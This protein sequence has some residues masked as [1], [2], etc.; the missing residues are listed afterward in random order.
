MKKLTCLLLLLFSLSS[1]GQNQK[2]PEIND[3]LFD[4]E[5]QGLVQVRPVGDIEGVAEHF[6]ALQNEGLLHVNSQNPK[7]WELSDQKK[8]IVFNGDYMRRGIYGIRSVRSILALQSQSPENIHIVI[9]NH[10]GN[11]LSWPAYHSAI[12]TKLGSISQRYSS[13]LE[14]NS[15]ENTLVNQVYFWL[16]DLGI[17]EKLTNFWLEYILIEKYGVEVDDLHPDVAKEFYSTQDGKTQI[18]VAKLD[19]VVSRDE[20]IEQ[21]LKFI[22]PGGPAFEILERGKLRGSIDFNGRKDAALI[23]FNHSGISSVDNFGVIPTTSEKYFKIRDSD[24]PVSIPSQNLHSNSSDRQRYDVWIENLNSNFKNS[25][26]AHLSS[27][28][29]GFKNSSDINE[30]RELAKRM[31]DYEIIHNLDA[32]WSDVSGMFFRSDSQVYPDPRTIKEN[33]LPGISSPEVLAVEAAIGIGIKLGGHKPV[34]DIATLMIGFD[35][36]SRRHVL[37]VYHDTSYSPVEGNNQISI[38]ENGAIRITGRLRDD[39]LVLMERPA[40]STMTKWQNEIE[41][42]LTELKEAAEQW[43]DANV[44]DGLENKYVRL[45]RYFRLGRVIGGRLIIGFKVNMFEGQAV[46]D[47]DTYVTVRQDGY[48]FKYQDIDIWG[49]REYE[50]NNGPLEYAQS[51]LGEMLLKAEVEK[52]KKLEEVGRTVLDEQDFTKA[53]NG[54][55]IRILSGPSANVKQVQND[56]EGGKYIEESL[57]AFRHELLAIPDGE[58]VVFLTGGT[59]GWESLKTSVIVEVN[60][61][62]VQSGKNPFRIIGCAALVF[63]VGEID[64]NIKEFFLIPKTFYWNDYQ[65]NLV[66]NYVLPSSAKKIEIDY[67]GGGS[68]VGTQINEAVSFAMSDSRVNVS[69]EMGVSVEPLNKEH[70]K[71]G[72]SDKFGDQLIDQ[73]LAHAEELRFVSVVTAKNGK[74]TQLTGRPS[75]RVNSVGSNTVLRPEGESNCSDLLE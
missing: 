16:G 20:A 36:K 18:D 66:K 2:L 48:K 61:I 7:G 29:D 33:S 32:K 3:E 70:K 60:K 19:Q 75:F 4:S 39:S 22:S 27:D 47:Y 65:H 46:V 42:H 44:P 35:I 51:D 59:E 68:I 1:F 43:R 63:G 10:D 15:L 40:E 62:R 34:G 71:R 53:L 45:D 21:F 9:G 31:A 13:W 23:D 5:V 37:S 26:L 41:P 24:T 58:E 74:L 50:K 55:T 54:K 30:K 14:S 17:T 56:S 52:S 28:F 49:V 69:V 12:E 8:V 64:P 67:A 73:S 72:A 25:E 38:Y 57:K 11:I 6:E